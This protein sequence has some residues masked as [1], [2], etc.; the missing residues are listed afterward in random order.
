MLVVIN[1]CQ[2]G[3]KLWYLCKLI[4]SVN[5]VD[6]SVGPRKRV[7]DITSHIGLPKGRWYQ[8][9][10]VIL[11]S[12]KERGYQTLL[13]T[14]SSQKERGY[15]TLLVTL[16]SQ[17][18]RGYQPLLVTL[19]SQKERGYQTL[20]VILSCLDLRSC[21]NVEVDILGS[22]SLIVLLVPVDIKQHWMNNCH[23]TALF[24]ITCNVKDSVA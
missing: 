7:S 11:S 15:Q 21:G 20:I 19:C 13:V 17:K 16:C 3:T 18:E 12:Q 9:L 1:T 24:T 8:T 2:Q 22:Q 14:L 23:T 4:S 6:R 10:L 5:T